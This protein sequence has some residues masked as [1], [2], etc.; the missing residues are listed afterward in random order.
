MRRFEIV[1]FFFYSYFFWTFD[2]CCS[3]DYIYLMCLVTL[4]FGV[5]REFSF[6]AGVAFL[7]EKIE[8]FEFL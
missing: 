4:V 8:Y 6:F 2:R 5:Y 7:E 1:F 3:A